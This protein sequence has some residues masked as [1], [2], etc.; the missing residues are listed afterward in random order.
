MLSIDVSDDSVDDIS[1]EGLLPEKMQLPSASTI[2]SQ[3]H[4]S[5]STI[6][7]QQP[8]E[9]PYNFVFDQSGDVDAF[10]T[11]KTGRKK[12]TMQKNTS[13][14]SIISKPQFKADSMLSPTL[15]DFLNE[16]SEEITPP[17]PRRPINRKPPDPP[18]PK[19]I[20]IEAE[21]SHPPSPTSIGIEAESSPSNSFLFG[22][23]SAFDATLLPF[24][25]LH[26]KVYTHDEISE[27]IG[28][29][30]RDPIISARSKTSHAAELCVDFSDSDHSPKQSRRDA[31]TPQS[32]VMSVTYADDFCSDSEKENDISHTPNTP[33]KDRHVRIT[34]GN[35]RKKHRMVDKGIQMVDKG[36]QADVPVD[37]GVQC[38]DIPWTSSTPQQPYG[39]GFQQ[40]HPFYPP[41]PFYPQAPYPMMPF[42]QWPL[43]QDPSS[44][45]NAQIFKNSV[46]DPLLTPGLEKKEGL[47]ENWA[48]FVSMNMDNSCLD[49][50]LHLKMSAE[51]NRLRLKCLI[52]RELAGKRGDV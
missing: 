26:Q 37:V 50:V 8:E 34:P 35:K 39:F 10:E 40:P 30:A 2:K 7:S 25:D 14:S 47:G 31:L 13:K 15:D 48:S 3:Q 43:F 42:Q 46:L 44:F 17:P 6:K 41:S 5:A 12:D 51:R 28:E 21:S 29:S 11:F 49:Q 23:V 9:D 4:L 27:R 52:D 33:K 45:A 16:D 38:D 18:T 19:S 36:I 22:K 24:Q 32:S 20:G 1:F